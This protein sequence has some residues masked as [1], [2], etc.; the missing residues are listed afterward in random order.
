MVCQCYGFDWL[1]VVVFEGG[2][3]VWWMVDV[4]Y[5]Y[6]VCEGGDIVMF[7]GKQVNCYFW[8]QLY[9]DFIWMC[10]VVVNDNCI[11]VL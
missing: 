6:Y 5:C 1:D 10:Y 11:N 7:V 3:E 9:W 4:G 8:V 2:E